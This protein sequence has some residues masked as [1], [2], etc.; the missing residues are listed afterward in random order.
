MDRAGLPCHSGVAPRG[1]GKLRG[2]PQDPDKVD[3]MVT[4][5]C[6]CEKGDPSLPMKHEEKLFFLE[7][8]SRAAMMVPTQRKNKNHTHSFKGLENYMYKQ[9]G[10]EN[11]FINTQFSY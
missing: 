9:K 2:T 7:A 11:P 10:G 1:P 3:N 6:E 8:V 4:S 5:Q